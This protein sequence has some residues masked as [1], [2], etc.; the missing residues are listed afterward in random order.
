MPTLAL[1][2]RTLGYD[3]TGDGP[4]VVLLHAFPFD[5]RFWAPT[6]ARLAPA[7]RVVTPDLRGFG[8][9]SPGPDGYGIADLAD[10][11]VRLLDALGLPTATVAGLSMGGYVALALAARHPGRLARL[12]LADTKAGPDTPEA[13]RGRDE[14]I[15]LVR[16][17]GVAPFADRQVPRLLA[18]GADARVRA[19]VRALMDQPAAGVVNALAALRDRPDR[20]A[21]LAAIACPTLVVVGAED[22][23]T[24]PAEARALAAAIPGA[25]LVELPGAGHLPNLETPDA[26]AAALADFVRA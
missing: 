13:R 21:D 1:P 22:A 10:D 26:L 11:V 24:P 7:A 23:L 16:A 17:E 9:S 5:R 25:R 15:A 20:R 6:V 19:D 12:V 18:P 14:A 4:P 8:A 3:V 2:D